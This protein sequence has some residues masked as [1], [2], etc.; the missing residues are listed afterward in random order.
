MKIEDTSL[1]CCTLIFYEYY[2]VSTLNE[3]TVLSSDLSLK[4]TKVVLSFY[5]ERPFIYI[6]HRK[7]SY[8]VDPL[9]HIQVSTIKNLLGFCVVTENHFNMSNTDIERLFLKK[10]FKVFP[11]LIEAKNWSSLLYNNYL[12]ELTNQ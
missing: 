3:G 6:T 10:P 2:V 11:T 7:N 9:I 1:D 8:S 5:G 4:I 12:S